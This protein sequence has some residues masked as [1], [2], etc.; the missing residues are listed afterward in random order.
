MTSFP[1]HD[2]Q[3]KAHKELDQVVGHIRLPD[4]GDE[5]K[6]P[7]IGA[8]LKEVHRY[9]V[10]SLYHVDSALSWNPSGPWL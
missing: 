1:D 7:Y 8:L 3:A 5:P 9:P 6:L 2:A 10:I 4:F